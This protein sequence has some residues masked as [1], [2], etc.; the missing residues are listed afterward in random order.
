MKPQTRQAGDSEEAC[1]GQLAPQPLSPTPHED[2][3]CLPPG[4]QS[5]T[6]RCFWLTLSWVPSLWQPWWVSNILF[7]CGAKDLVK[8]K[9][10]PC[11]LTPLQNHISTPPLS[12]SS[13]LSHPP[14]THLGTSGSIGLGPAWGSGTMVVGKPRGHKSQCV[15]AGRREGGTGS[16]V[17]GGAEPLHS[18]PSQAPTWQVQREQRGS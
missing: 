7:L 12:S 11:S 2:A 10:D 9:D 13:F 17:S 16:W 3:S 6:R 18:G 8:A 4:H 14:A 1:G 15:S 5:H